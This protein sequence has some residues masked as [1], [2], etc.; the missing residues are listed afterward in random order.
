MAMQQAS[1]EKA[2]VLR[3]ILIIDHALSV[4]CIVLPLTHV[5]VAVRVLAESV[6]L[7]LPVNEI[8]LIAYASVLDKH[9]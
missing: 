5:H 8:A 9:A 4:L 3:A 6:A 7:E 2:F 1:L